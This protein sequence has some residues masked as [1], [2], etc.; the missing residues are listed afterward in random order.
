MQRHR[1]KGYAN[2][3][4]GNQV[5]NQFEAWWLIGDTFGGEPANRIHE[6]GRG[7]DAHHLRVTRPR[8]HRPTAPVSEYNRRLDKDPADATQQEIELGRCDFAKR[9][10]NDEFQL[11]NFVPAPRASAID[12]RSDRDRVLPS[13]A[14][15][16]ARKSIAP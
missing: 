6:R 2:R 1:A 9:Y 13:A 5:S 16:P 15:A 8:R 7:F 4:V 12:P 10:Q 14:G 11:L 3:G